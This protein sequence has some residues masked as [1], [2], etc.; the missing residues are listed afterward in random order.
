[1]GGG[2]LRATPAARKKGDA[3]QSVADGRYGQP[4]KSKRIAERRSIRR[5][6]SALAATR[7][8]RD[9]TQ[10]SAPNVTA[11][12]LG[13]SPCASAGVTDRCL[14]GRPGPSI[15]LPSAVNLNGS[16]DLDE[17]A[18][19]PNWQRI[20]KRRRPRGQAVRPALKAKENCGRNSRGHSRA[21]GSR[22]R[23]RRYRPCAAARRRRCRRSRPDA[24][25]RAD[26]R[27]SARRS[28]SR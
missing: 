27:F 16:A 12:D 23:L 3:V 11:S 1:M 24:P 21:R 26:R 5:N 17:S 14:Y 6:R 18:F 4:G 22:W 19:T 2:C 8:T 9:D 7:R 10:R 28:A 20:R 13:L 15:S 25:G